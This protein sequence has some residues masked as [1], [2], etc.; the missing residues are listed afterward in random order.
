VMLSADCEVGYYCM[1]VHHFPGVAVSSMLRVYDCMTISLVEHCGAAA[2]CLVAFGCGLAASGPS[3]QHGS[4]WP[5]VHST[6]A[7][8]L[9]QQAATCCDAIV[10]A[11]LQCR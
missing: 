1:P 6:Q 11:R 10:A 8:H 9:L 4:C 3:W 7:R 5:S 2:G